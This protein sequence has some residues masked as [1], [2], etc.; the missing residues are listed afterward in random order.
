M[1]TRAKLV[2]QKVTENVVNDVKDGESVEFM[3][4]YNAEDS[5]ED[6]SF[7]KYTPSATGTFYISNPELFG[8]FVVGKAYYFDISEA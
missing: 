5:P 7:S 3:T 1:N 4:Q 2:C 6:N 8:N